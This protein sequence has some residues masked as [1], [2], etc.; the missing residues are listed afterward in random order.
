MGTKEYRLGFRGD[1]E[2]LRAVAILLVVAAHAGVP[3]L[4]GGFVG[5]D[6]FFVLS[7]YLITG[8]LV[9]EMAGSN[10]L[11]FLAFY[12]RRLRRL[13]PA[14]LVM[15]LVTCLLAAQ[16]LAPVEQRGQ[17]SAS[18]MAAIWLSNVHFA[19]AK[20]DYFSPGSESNLFLHT[21]S[22][23]VEEQFYLLWPALLLAIFVGRNGGK[24]FTRLKWAMLIILLASFA[25]CVVLTQTSPQLAFYMMPM[26]A[27]Q[28]SLGALVWLQ[29]QRD[30]NNNIG[31]R[32]NDVEY[33]GLHLAGWLGLALI[34]GAGLLLSANV[35]YP[36]WWAFLPT[37]GAGCVLA[38]GY[39]RPMSGVSRLLSWQPM[40][41]IG[42]ISYSWY[43]WHWP[44]L[45]LG[46]FAFGIN[47][48]AYRAAE[49]LVSLVLAIA[50]YVVIEAP[51]R[52]QSGWLTH[53]RA[54]LIGA[55]AIM[56][57][58]NVASIHWFNQ[59]FDQMRSPETQRFT[60]AHMDAPII[61]SQGCDDWYQSSR[62]NICAFGAEDAKH[63]AVL[64]GDSIAGQWFPAV[65]TAFD[66]PGW[67]LLV[68]TKSACPMVDEPF[69]YGRIGRE[70]TECAAWRAA[71]LS[72]VAAIKPDVVLLG[73]AEANGF[74]ESQWIDGSTRVMNVISPASGHVYVL[75]GTPSLPFDGPDCLAE[76]QGRPKWLSSLRTCS[77]PL[78]NAHS[79]MVFHWLQQ[80]A[81]RYGNATAMDLNDLVCPE[82]V[83]RAELQGRIVFRDSQHM[84]ASFAE[85]LGGAMQ[86]RLAI[87][88]QSSG[89]G[90][91]TAI[92]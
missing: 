9:Q 88:Q 59:A 26:R 51:I 38:A 67:R 78:N 45:L 85:S 64:M 41:M 30:G 92:Q 28:F 77:A 3:W 13:L 70:Y 2:G 29:F 5:V 34:V 32:T 73:S 54:A 1:I 53:R 80:V 14:L 35:S 11:D 71:S 37:I 49:V 12:V 40:Q 23:G 55:V 20:L 31:S 7:G 19:L 58:A 43:L 57:V 18:A 6:V 62:V 63:T 66:R 25:S 22:L 36:G 33:K 68:L 79:D 48:P 74:T 86:Q 65:A 17:A 39:G 72:R 4:T 84:T 8:L 90:S 82:G 69:F 47:S 15:L 56:V 81:S 21:W 42:K 10:R 83:C 61:Y 75:R 16:L 76:N 89:Q 24:A 50:S 52:H 87:D 27:W 46:R 91:P 60:R 44:V